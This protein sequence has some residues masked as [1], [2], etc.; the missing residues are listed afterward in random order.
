MSD[1]REK[2]NKLLDELSAN[3]IEYIYHLVTKLF[4]R[5]LSD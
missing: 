3:K 4:F 2:L 5:Q 1:Y